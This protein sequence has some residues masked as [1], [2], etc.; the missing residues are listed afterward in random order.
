MPGGRRTS[1]PESFIILGWLPLSSGTDTICIYYLKVLPFTRHSI[2]W[3]VCAI[4]FHFAA[5]SRKFQTDIADP[6]HGWDPCEVVSKGKAWGAN[7]EDLYGCL[8]FFLTQEL[9]EFH[10]R[11][12]RFHI[13]FKI[14]CMDASGLSQLLLNTQQNVFAKYDLP[15]STRFDRIMVSNILD[16]IYVGLKDTLTRWAP[17]LSDS[18][19]SVTVGYFMNWFAIQPDGRYI[20]EKPTPR[21]TISTDD[22]AYLGRSSTPPG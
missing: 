2:Q 12:Q 19:I 8:Y 7:P 10:R 9:R 5:S 13:A 22:I 1:L 20:S 15:A 3:Y 14:T 16:H 6:L 17:L 4:S 21:P 11:L 18:P